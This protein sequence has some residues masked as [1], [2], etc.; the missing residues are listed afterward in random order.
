MGQNTRSYHGLD[1]I[2]S[3][4]CWIG[5]DW[6][7]QNGPMSNSGITKQPNLAAIIQSWPLSI[8]GHIARMDDDADANMFLTAPLQRNGRDQQGVLKSRG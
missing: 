2:G 4:S 7:L 8:F 6:M 3:L 5:L 1:W